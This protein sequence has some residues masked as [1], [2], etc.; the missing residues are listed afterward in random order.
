MLKTRPVSWLKAARKDFERFPRGA[1]AELA[2]A[3]S[4]VAEGGHPDTAKPLRGFGSGV[5]ELALRF[6]NDAFRVVYAVQIGA[7]V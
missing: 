7:D 4:M 6:R 3:L 1:Q 2:R 5:F